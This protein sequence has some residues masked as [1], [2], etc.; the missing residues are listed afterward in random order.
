MKKHIIILLSTL[1][2]TS[3][4]I[5]LYSYIDRD[6]GSIAINPQPTSHE[7][8]SICRFLEGLYIDFG[9]GTGCLRESPNIERDRCY[10]N[11]NS[12]ALAIL[13]MCNSSIVPKIEAFLNEYNHEY[14]GRFEVMLLHDIPYPPRAVER[15]TL[16]KKTVDNE[17]ITIYADIPSN[18][19]LPDW[20]RYADMLMLAAL[21]LLKNGDIEKAR[22]Y[23]EEVKKMW[24]GKGFA[25]KA[26]NAT[27]IYDTYK[28]SLYYFISK[29][30]GEKDDIAIWIENNIHRFIKNGGVITS[31]DNDLNLV[32]DPNIETT[33]V[34]AIALYT[35]YPNAFQLYTKKQA[36]PPIDIAIPVAICTTV[37]AIL[38]IIILIYKKKQIQ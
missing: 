25:D 16:D 33:A 17:T 26:Y 14:G 29:T 7:I 4:A 30:M 23:I 21:Q 10:T 8:I 20:N 5:L 24:S 34:T 12:I 31:Y 28:L 11:T 32:G 6:R 22:G 15:L 18:T 27:D 38:A 35:N 19:T 2:L 36:L 3:I 9:D 37:I 13:K 1:L